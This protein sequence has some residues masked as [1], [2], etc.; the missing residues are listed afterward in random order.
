MNRQQRRA[1]AK[2]QEQPG[3]DGAI[4]VSVNIDLG[5]LTSNAPASSNPPPL[6]GKPGFL[7]RCFASILLSRWVLKRVH[8]PE[9]ERLLIALAMEGGR[10]EVA[11]ELVR[12]QAMRTQQIR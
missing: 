11:D 6:K 9:A 4:D 7:S 2:S 1:A 12:R 3:Q 10:P 5:S 8:H